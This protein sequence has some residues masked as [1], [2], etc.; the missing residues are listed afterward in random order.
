MSPI[1]WSP[2][3]LPEDSV[4]NTGNALTMSHNSFTKEWE[5]GKEGEGETADSSERWEG[6]G[7]LRD[8]KGEGKLLTALKGGKGKP[9]TS[10]PD[11][12]GE[13]VDSSD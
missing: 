3:Q 2:E 8:E 11:R 7:T 9:L 12:K 4:L 5:G 1:E 13:T 6:R 10:P